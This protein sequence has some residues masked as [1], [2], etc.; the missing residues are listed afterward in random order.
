MKIIRA[1]A[2]GMCFGVR[3]AL[4]VTRRIAD[5]AS[6]TI[7]G[8][9]V[10]NPRVV[11]ELSARGFTV[12]DETE[13]RDATPATS[14]V[15]ITAHGISERERKRLE[16]RGHE[17]IDTTCPLVR[18]AHAAACKLARMGCLVLVIG[19]RGHVEVEGLTGDLEQCEVVQSAAEVRAYDAP[20]LGIVC[21]T[22]TAPAVA[23]QIVDRIKELNPDREIHLIATICRPTLDR[24][25]AVRSLLGRVD[26]LVVVGGRRSNNTRQLAGLAEAAGKPWLHVE[27]PDELQPEWFAAF[28]TVGLT[29]GT[30][31]PDDVIG[32]VHQRLRAIAA[33]HERDQLPEAM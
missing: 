9:L 11:R 15:M 18:R 27:G 16:E 25:A 3:D 12:L 7:H 19:R 33:A 8:E 5:P 28:E 21:Q 29:A 30:S 13:R 20:R 2:M 24:Q 31:T 4:G 17:L 14:R 26:A 23:N 32:A 22:T 6:V 10:H 1:E